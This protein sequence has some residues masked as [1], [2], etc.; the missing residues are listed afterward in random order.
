MV[1]VGARRDGMGTANERK[2]WQAKN[3]PQAACA[4]HSNPG[5]VESSWSVPPGGNGLAGLRKAGRAIE[6]CATAVQARPTRGG[7]AHPPAAA[8]AIWR[9]PRSLSRQRSPISPRTSEE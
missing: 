3:W 4:L 1:E 2:N 9:E 6:C 8:S 5:F 7:R